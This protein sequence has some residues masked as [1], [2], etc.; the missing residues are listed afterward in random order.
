MVRQDKNLRE[1]AGIPGRVNT[2]GLNLS[3]EGFMDLLQRFNFI[4]GRFCHKECC[5]VFKPASPSV[6]ASCSK[7]VS[8]SSTI[9]KDR[10]PYLF[11]TPSTV[12]EIVQS[13]DRL[14][15]TV[16]NAAN[17][18]ESMASF[19]ESKPAQQ[20][21]MHLMVHEIDSLDFRHNS[22]SY[23]MSHCVECRCCVIRSSSSDGSG[24]TKSKRQLEDASSVTCDT[25]KNKNRNKKRRQA[26]SKP[27]QGMAS[28]HATCANLAKSPDGMRLKARLSN[29]KSQVKSRDRQ[30]KRLEATISNLKS[31]SNKACSE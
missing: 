3:P 13:T 24:S 5:G 16:Q 20:F 12:A 19:E 14:R 4:N 11:V 2:H 29:R 9:R 25:C 18:H 23:I 10:T 26:R 27:E 31:E 8:A 15:S 30:I 17:E 28:S 22:N 21:A 7:C 1:C 6:G